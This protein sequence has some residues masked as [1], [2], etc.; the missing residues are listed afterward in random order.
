MCEYVAA[1]ITVRYEIKRKRRILASDTMT[2]TYLVRNTPEDIE[3]AK[4]NYRLVVFDFATVYASLRDDIQTSVIDVDIAPC[5]EHF[6]DSYLRKELSMIDYW[7]V[8]KE[9]LRKLD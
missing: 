3:N 1:T 6:S 9:A 8:Q 4:G 5:Y 2:K 7:K